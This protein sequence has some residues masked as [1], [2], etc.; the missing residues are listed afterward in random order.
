MKIHL[1][2]PARHISLTI[3]GAIICFASFAQGFSPQV[4]AKLQRVIDSIQ[5]Y[6]DTP[7]VG[8]IAAAINVDG[9]ALWK[10]ATGYAARNI[11]EQNNLL[12]GGTPFT[13][14]TLSRIYSITKSFTAALV[15]ELANDGAFSLNDPV[16][17][18]VPSITSIN[19]GL[20]PYVTIHQL[21]AHESGYSD[22]V[23]ELNLQIAVASDPNRVWTTYDM[24]A[25]VHQIAPPGSERRYASTNYSLLGAIIEVA[26]GKKVEELFR[27]RFF[28]KLGLNSM[29][30]AIR[31]SIDDRGSLAS[32]HDN[33]SAFNPIFQATGQ[34]TFPDTFTNISR[35]PMTAI[36]SLAF[37]NGGIVSN[38]A[39]VAKWGNDL[40]GGRATSK[41]ILD[42]M[43]HS[44]SP[45][46][47]ED[48]D[49]LGYG[50]TYNKQISE[51]DSFIGHNGNAVGYKS[52]MFYQLDRKMTIAV[53]TNF[54]GANEYGIGRAL[55]NALPNFLCG[56][57]DNRVK[58]CFKGYT[59]CLPRAAARFIINRGAY[60][61]GCGGKMIQ[62]TDSLLTAILSPSELASM[63]IQ[64]PDNGRNELTVT[65]NP[66]NKSA[67]FT[68]KVSQP[69]YADLRVY[70]MAGKQVLLLFNGSMD[71]G[72]VRQVHFN[73][74]NL[75]S[76]VYI[77][78][79]QTTTGIIEKKLVLK[80]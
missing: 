74:S 24:L 23:D 41:A 71:K 21:V 17:K 47:D 12:P 9:L 30:L 46:P 52:I 39:D 44:I 67:L 72:E 3:F 56:S 15:L 8:G 62:N 2:C 76:G 1:N 31:E 18:Y 4:Q 20:N 38:V 14:D 54:H 16:I 68:F 10:G 33:I 48:G 13:T 5:N 45:Y 55:Y 73:A 78:R 65:P 36:A 6:A 61:G 37:T 58:V 75:S 63:G 7:Y 57:K 77:A 50:I 19:P 35:F 11:D 43:L 59:L 34:P 53:L 25:F 70:D 27:Q 26:T 49:Y 60:L 69:G 79:L 51:T 80:P 42:T 40:F 28:N 22:Y 64:K 29:Y 32:P 66:I